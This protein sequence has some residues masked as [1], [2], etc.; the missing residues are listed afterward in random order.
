MMYFRLRLL[1]ALLVGGCTR[2]M[3]VVIDTNNE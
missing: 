1:I 3:R 2:R